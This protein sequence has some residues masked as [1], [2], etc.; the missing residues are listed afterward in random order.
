MSKAVNE[1]LARED[2]PAGAKRK[3]GY[4]NP[5]RLYRI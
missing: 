1:F 5:K 3:I 2:I 4:D